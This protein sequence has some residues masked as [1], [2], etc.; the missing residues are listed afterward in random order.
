MYNVLF[1]ISSISILFF[2]IISMFLLKFSISSHSLSTFPWIL[3][4]AIVILP[5]LTRTVQV[6]S[7]SA[8]VDHGSPF[9]A[10]SLSVMFGCVPDTA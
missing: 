5:S 2:F 1:F 7:G 9:L 3:T 8:S 10:F 6:I 4:S